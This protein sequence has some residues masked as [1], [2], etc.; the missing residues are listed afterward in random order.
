[1]ATTAIHAEIETASQPSWIFLTDSQK[2]IAG[3]IQRATLKKNLI[4][5][6]GSFPSA[7]VVVYQ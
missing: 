5:G 7:S 3:T 2:P 6:S 1:M 4:T